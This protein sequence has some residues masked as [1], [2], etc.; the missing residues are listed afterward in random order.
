MPTPAVTKAARLHRL[1]SL[2][3]SH[4]S[5]AADLAKHFHVGK[6]TIHRDLHELESLGHHLELRGRR[7]S[8]RPVSTALNA[9][10]ALAVHSATRLLV[11][12][13]RINEPHYRSAL[14]KLA[15]HLPD[16]ARRYLLASVDDI[17][18]L[19]SAGGRTL[20]QV[21]QAWFEH[22]VLRFDYAAPIGS[23]RAHRNELEV[24]FF[25][26][27]P[28]NLAPYVI[29]YERTYFRDVRTFR[30]DR[31]TNASVLSDQYVIPDSFD[32][33]TLLASAWGIVGGPRLEVKLRVHGRFAHRIDDRPHR[34]L[35]VDETTANG[36]LLVTITCGQDKHGVPI[37]VL[38]WLLGWGA[39]V[40]VVGPEHVRDV[41]R[42]E[43]RA[44][45]AA[46]ATD[47]PIGTDP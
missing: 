32:P 45:A 18:A 19:S 10:E 43:L 41:L 40:E 9:V 15:A 37:D 42:R 26:I 1:A 28:I 21:A 35:R 16:P 2:L 46:Y 34:N 14:T 4:P 5:S 7:Y 17:G 23:G 29:G 25:E 38:P 13:T 6:R 44:A 39:G 20:D 12:H 33:H 47:D 3:E 36:D 22:R 31:I 11:H 27:S 8:L 30:L 24:Y